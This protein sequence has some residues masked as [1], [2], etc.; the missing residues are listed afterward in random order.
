MPWSFLKAPGLFRRDGLA[1]PIQDRTG[2]QHEALR[3]LFDYWRDKTKGRPVPDRADLD[4]MEMVPW[5][6]HLLLVEICEG[7]ADIRFRLIGTWVVDRIGRDDTGRTMSELGLTE[8]RSR[9]RDAYLEVA[10]LGRPCRR[11]GEFHDRSGVRK[12]LWAERILLPLTHGG[13][14][15]AMILSAIYFLDA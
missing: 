14:E 11:V 8:G 7:Q 9:I 5:L 4:P 6:S 3:G 10:R 1:D 13:S 2:V 12:H 15:I